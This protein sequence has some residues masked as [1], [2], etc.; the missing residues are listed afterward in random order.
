MSNQ[1]TLRQL[2]EMHLNGMANFFEDNV[3]NRSMSEMNF[4][5]LFALIVDAEYIR[6]KNNQIARLIKNA[7]FRYSKACIEKIDYREDRKLNKNLLL[8]LATCNYILKAQNILIVGATGSGKS[9]LSCA[10]G[11]SAC[12]NRFSVK[13]IRLPELLD[14]LKMARYDNRFRKVI[15]QYTKPQL[16]ILDEWLLTDLTENEARDLMEIVEAR[17][18]LSSTIFCSQYKKEGWRQKI[19]SE[20]ISEAILDRITSNAHLISIEGNVSMRERKNSD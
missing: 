13:Y 16:L 6:R 2:R 18:E 14:E 1:E 10:L 9:Y 17:A 3:C 5:E 15:D 4:E 11:I 19:G 12:R 7:K 20:T 8:K